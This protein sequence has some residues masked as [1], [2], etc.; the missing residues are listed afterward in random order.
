MMKPAASR[1]GPQAVCDPRRWGQ[2]QRQDDDDRQ[3]RPAISRRRPSRR[4]WR[5]ATFG[6]AAA[7]EQLQDLGRAQRAAVIIT[8]PQGRRGGQ[9]RLWGRAGRGA[10]DERRRPLLID[11]AGRLH[12]KADLV[13]ELQKLVRSLKKLEPAAPRPVLLVLTRRSAGTRTP[14]PRWGHTPGRRRHRHRDD[15]ARRQPQKGGVLVSLAEKPRHA[16]PK[17]R[18]RQER[19][20]FA[21]PF[22]AYSEA[23]G[24]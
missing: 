7:V 12:N 14:R 1:P 18:H 4:V 5:R 11:T 13:A 6:R 20:G 23:R 19:R 22:E 16:D 8:R 9:A 15:Q 21:K 2:Q 10:R 24:W 17:N 3:A